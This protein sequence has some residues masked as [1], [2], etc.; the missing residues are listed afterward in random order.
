MKLQTYLA[1]DIAG[2]N[3]KNYNGEDK[4][5]IEFRISNGTTKSKVMKEN[6][7][8]YGKLVELSKEIAK[9]GRKQFCRTITFK[10]FK[11]NES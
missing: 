5:T 9:E 2:L 3:L 4:N 6:I 8:L 7:L 11:T 1:E 10:I